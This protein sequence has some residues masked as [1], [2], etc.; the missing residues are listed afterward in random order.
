M[1]YLPGEEIKASIALIPNKPGVYEFYDTD[2]NILYVGKAKKLKKRVQSYFQKEHNSARLK[3]LVKKISS[4]E[5]TTVATDQ[6]AFLLENN[7]IKEHQP[8]YNIQLKDDKSYPYIVIRNEPIPRLYFTRRKVQDG[9]EYFGP[10]TGVKHVRAILN[11]AKELHPLRTCKLDLSPS[12]IQQKKYKVC[13]EYHIGNCLAP[14]IGEQ[15]AAEYDEGIDTIRKILEGKTGHLIE[16]L[17][18]RRNQATEELNYELAHDFQKKIE[19]IQEFKRPSLVENLGIERADVYQIVHKENG[20]AIHHI[21]IREYSIV[22]STINQVIPKLHEEDDELLLHAIRKFSMAGD[23]ESIPPIIAPIDLDFPFAPIIVPERGEKNKI[24]L[25]MKKN[26]MEHQ[27]KTKPKLNQDLLE[28]IQKDLRLSSLPK[29]IECFDNSNIQGSNPVASCV[30]F[31]NGRPAKSAYRHFNVKTVV[32]PDD[33]ASMTEIVKRRYTGQLKKGESLPDLIV[34][35]G[36]KGQ[37]NAAIEALKEVGIYQDVA[38]IGIAK[39][40]EELF[41]PNDPLPL[42]L[43]KRSPALKLMQQIRNEAH[44]FAIT[45]HRKKRSQHFTRT[46]LESIQGI[47][48]KTAIQLLRSFGSVEAIKKAPLQEIASI[49]GQKKAQLIKAGLD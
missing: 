35:D 44:R 20:S 33:Y 36:G 15:S 28:Q 8:K 11:L 38:V 26:L 4:I 10:Y 37:L 32:G 41:Y 22:F 31:V 46:S 29:H 47:G 2:K 13:L 17:T 14:C 16:T 19:K 43:N 40:L 49:I 23:L 7:L 1:N 25:M 24:L 27:F 12:K 21:K 48:E 18:E 6:E 45:F 9:S 42:M 34:I 30:V 3:L 39:Q 5:F